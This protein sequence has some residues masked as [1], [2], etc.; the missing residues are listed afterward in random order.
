[1]RPQ[2]GPHAAP[3]AG[4]PTTPADSAATP[5]DS[6]AVPATAEDPAAVSGQDTRAVGLA[7]VRGAIAVDADTAPAIARATHDLLT[8]LLTANR[9]E[10]DDLVSLMFTQTPDLT[11]T[12]PALALHEAGWDLPA[13]CA[14][15][16]AFAG[17]PARTLR[18]LAHLRWARPGRP[19]PAYLAGAAPT[20]PA[21]SGPGSTRE[22][23]KV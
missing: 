14:Q 23:D 21:G 19:V 11:A 22:P 7:A 1:M 10:R 15:D 5:A 18:V 17:A 3:A 12:N 6:A 16:A 13:L 20:R 9:L 4:S 8:A 2:A